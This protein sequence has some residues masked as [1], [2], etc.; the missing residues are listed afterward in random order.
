MTAH[1]LPSLRAAAYLAAALLAGAFLLAAP[2]AEAAA[3][4]VVVTENVIRLGDLFQTD[5]K[6]AEIPVARAP[7]PGQRVALDGRW[8]SRLARAHRVAWRPV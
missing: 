8:L 1:P 4:K 6:R 5:D 3:S 2:G 7:A